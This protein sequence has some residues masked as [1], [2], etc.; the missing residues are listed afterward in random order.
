MFKHI[1]AYNLFSWANLEYEIKP[2]ISQITG[3]NYDDNSPEGCGKSSVPNILCW[4]LYG[5]IPK[6]AKIDEVIREGADSGGG[7]VVFT[8][9]HTVQRTRK[10]NSLKILGPDGQT[11]Q[12]K[13]A[14][15]TQS[16]INTLVGLDFDAFCQTIYFSQSYPQKFVTASET[17]KVAILSQVLDLTVFDKA[18]KRAQDLTKQADTQVQKLAT[19]FTLNAVEIKRLASNAEILANVIAKFED[20]KAANIAA[21]KQGIEAFGEQIKARAQIES[22][23]KKADDSLKSLQ[24][25][26]EVLREKRVELET[27]IKIAQNDSGPKRSVVERNIEALLATVSKRRAKVESLKKAGRDCP[28]CGE[29]LKDHKLHDVAAGLQ[30]A[31][32]ELAE[33]LTRVEQEKVVLANIP[34]PADISAHQKALSALKEKITANTQM[35]TDMQS[36]SALARRQL[37]TLTRVE[38]DLKVLKKRLATLEESS[39]AEELEKLEVWD[40]R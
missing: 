40:E 25:K 8:N 16:L 9:G 22:E 2:G 7:A 20:E 11:I 17:E 19:D 13:D 30:D 34:P 15:E 36:A 23:L 18:R 37:D 3:F 21:V 39:P 10:P 14:K 33:A 29:P 35:Q 12:G 5:R 28:T 1:S 26:V 31:Q 32:E 24:D 4:T 6:D 38:K 27:S